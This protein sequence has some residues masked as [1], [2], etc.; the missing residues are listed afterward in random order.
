M[1][2]ENF[3]FYEVKL[4]FGSQHTSLYSGRDVVICLEGHSKAPFAPEDGENL[5]G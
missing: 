2:Y 5:K 3:T 4:V 1:K